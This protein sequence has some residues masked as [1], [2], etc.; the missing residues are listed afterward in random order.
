MIIIVCNYELC[1]CLYDD[2]VT[3]MIFACTGQCPYNTFP[4]VCTSLTQYTEGLPDPHL[5]LFISNNVKS[6]RAVLRIK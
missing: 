6:S 1:N 3:P 5:H 4:K 2:L